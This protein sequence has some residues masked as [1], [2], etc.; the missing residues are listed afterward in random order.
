MSCSG[1]PGA[2]LLQGDDLG[3]FK[4]QAT[5]TENSCGAGALGSIPQWDFSVELSQDAG[6]LFWDGRAASPLVDQQFEFSLSVAVRAATAGAS[7]TTAGCQVIREDTISGLL[8]LE[9]PGAG[10]FTGELRYDYDRSPGAD[11]AA[12]TASSSG[13][14]RLPCTMRYALTGVQTRAPNKEP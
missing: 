7:G 10:G 12:L 8:E 3:T 6:E 9:P 11:C 14:A 5:E 13:L 1:S 4:V 2:G